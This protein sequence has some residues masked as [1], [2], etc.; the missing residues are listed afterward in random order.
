[1]FW[2]S[3]GPD[4]LAGYLRHRQCAGAGR[5]AAGW[6]PSV[7]QGPLP[8]P[9]TA[10]IPGQSLAPREAC[11]MHSA[12]PLQTWGLEGQAH[13]C[14]C[15]EPTREKAKQI[16]VRAETAE[17]F[18]PMTTQCNPTT[19]RVSQERHS[20]GLLQPGRFSDSLLTPRGKTG[21]KRYKQTL[22]PFFLK[23]PHI[24]SHVS[25]SIPIISV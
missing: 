2:G 9:A 14:S 7:P 25:N 19:R 10:A 18:S 6:V 24:S 13:R 12:S 16:P 21:K 8:F 22:F 15:S 5:A 23:I 4:A 1:M 20:S 11:Q 17:G 3:N